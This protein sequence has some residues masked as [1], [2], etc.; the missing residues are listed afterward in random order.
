MFKLCLFDIDQTLVETSNL[1]WLRDIINEN[2]ER[3]S[4]AAITN[5]IEKVFKNYPPKVFFD[6]N[7]L[8][9]VRSTFPDLKIGIF[10]RTHR[11]YAKSLL[12]VVYPHF[13]W[14]ICVCYEDVSY[15]KPY[16]EGIL[17]A[18][19]CLEITDSQ[20]VL[21][22]GDDEDDMY[23]AIRAGARSVLVV[24]SWSNNIWPGRGWNRERWRAYRTFPDAVI[25]NTSEI[26]QVLD[27]ICQFLPA[28]ESALET[29][30][31]KRSKRFRETS[32]FSPFEKTP[33]GTDKRYAILT[34]GRY[35]PVGSVLHENHSS[36]QS[37][38]ACKDTTVFPQSWFDTLLDLVSLAKGGVGVI[39]VIPARSEDS[40]QRMATFLSQFC[41]YISDKGNFIHCKLFVHND[42]FT[43]TPGARSHH[44]NHLSY[45]ERF[46]NVEKHLKIK[47]SDGN[48]EKLKGLRAFFLIVDDV[49]TT[50][51]TL[52]CATRRLVE[53]GIPEKCVIRFSFTATVSV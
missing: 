10:T 33:Y 25:S 43:Y 53:K 3:F 21:M 26:T 18:M 48:V 29:K 19:R 7:L 49:C 11:N 27:D 12:S 30:T 38:L 44:K 40:C 4:I 31:Q 46:E 8:N 14:D 20:E 6:L 36:T 32:G 35:F 45:L 39:T 24:T 23:A 1:Q 42:F 2:P 51:A 37:I 15:T 50:G 34:A 47:E 5:S 9:K 52:V 41:D 22:V 28:L 13:H 17:Y 16:P